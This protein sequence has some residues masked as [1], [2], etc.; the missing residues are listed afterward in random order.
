MD[1][2]H[3]IE[4]PAL[5]SLINDLGDFGLDM[6]SICL[7]FEMTYTLPTRRV[8]AHRAKEYDN[9]TAPR[10]GNCVEESSHIYRIW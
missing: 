7:V 5:A 3:S 4:R 6:L 1:G 2:R 10:S 8:I 9:R